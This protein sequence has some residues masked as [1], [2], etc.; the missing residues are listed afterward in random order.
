[1]MF[2]APR[3]PT[4][5]RVC[6]RHDPAPF[7]AP[8]EESKGILATPFIFVPSSF[9][10]VLRP[11]FRAT[12]LVGGARAFQLGPLSCLTRST[13]RDDQPNSRWFCG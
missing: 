7:A 2:R 11:A 3:Y 4:K 9:R 13:C 1:M 10:L 6:G 5:G 12:T 8:S